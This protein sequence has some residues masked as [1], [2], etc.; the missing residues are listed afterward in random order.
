MR[1]N[2]PGKVQKFCTSALS[3]LIAFQLSGIPQLASYSVAYADENAPPTIEIVEDTPADLTGDPNPADGNQPGDD[4]PLEG[5]PIPAEGETPDPNPAEGDPAASDVKVAGDFVFNTKTNTIVDWVGTSTSVEIPATLE[6]EGVEYPVEHIGDQAFDLETGR[7]PLESITLNEGLKTIGSFAFSRNNIAFLSIP[8]S[9]VEIKDSA[10]E[11]N[12]LSD[13]FSLAI[14]PNSELVKIGNLAFSDNDLKGLDLTNAALLEEIGESAFAINELTEIKLPESIKKI[15]DRAFDQNDLSTVTLPNGLEEYGQEVFTNNGKY[16]VVSSTS[17]AVKD[18]VVEGKFG[19]V[20]HPVSIWITGIDTETGKTILTPRLYEFNSHIERKYDKLLLKGNVFSFTDV[21]IDNYSLKSDND[22]ELSNEFIEANSKENPK[23]LRYTPNLGDPIIENTEPMYIKFGTPADQVDLLKGVTAHDKAGDDLTDRLTAT[24]ATLDLNREGEYQIK[25]SVVDDNKRESIAYRTVFVGKDPLDVETGYGWLMRDFTYNGDT[26]T[27][28]SNTGR[29]KIKTHKKIVFPDFNPVSNPDGSNDTITM[30][31]ADDTF[32][33]K[34]LLEVVFPEKLTSFGDTKFNDNALTEVVIPKGIKAIPHSIFSDNKISSI[35]F[36]EGLESI[37]SI[38]FKNNELTYVDLPQNLKELDDRCFAYNKIAGHLDIP[39]SV[40][41]FGSGVFSNNLITSFTLPDTATEI[42]RGM[43]EENLI[44]DVKIPSTVTVIGQDAFKNNPVESIEFHDDVTEIG[45]NAFY[46]HHLHLDELILPSNIKVIKDEAFAPAYT[47]IEDQPHID[48]IV[49]PESIETIGDNAFRDNHIKEL[50]LPSHPVD[51][52]TG[53]FKNNDLTTVTIPDN[54]TEIADS[55]FS[56]NKLT[57]IHLPDSLV[58][59]GN[60]TFAGNELTEIQYPASLK[61]IGNKAFE[62]NDLTAV[63]IPEGIVKIGEGAFQDNAITSVSTPST[64][65]KISDKAFYGNPVSELTMSEGLEVIDDYAFGASVRGHNLESITFPASLKDIDTG[66]FSN[67]DSNS[68]VLKHIEFAPGSQLESIGSDAFSNNALTEVVL[69]P[70]VTS[71]QGSAFN[72]NPGW[73]PFPGRN[74]WTI[75]TTPETEMLKAPRVK[76]SIEKDGVPFTPDGLKDKV[77]NTYVA[78]PSILKIKHV[79]ANDPDTEIANATYR[80]AKRGENLQ[81]RPLASVYFQPVDNVATNVLMDEDVKEVVIQYN[82]TPEFDTTHFNI[83]MQHYDLRSGSR[84]EGLKDA[85]YRSNTFNFVVTVTSE[86]AESGASLHEP[87]VYIDLNQPVSGRIR[88]YNGVEL[89]DGNNITKNSTIEDGILRVQLNGDLNPGDTKDL[90]LTIRLNSAVPR[91]AIL[92]LTNAASLVVDEGE[93]TDGVKL[94]SNVNKLGLRYVKNPGT[95]D[96]ER[97]KNRASAPSESKDGMLFVAEGSPE[98]ND[99]VLETT[100]RL[101]DLPDDLHVKYP[102]PTYHGLDDQGTFK[103]DL[104]AEFVP[105]KNPAW[106]IDPT[107]EF[108]VA[109]FPQ[110][111]GYKAPKFNFPRARMNFPIIAE[112]LEFRVDDQ[113]VPGVIHGTFNE[114][115]DKFNAGNFDNIEYGATVQTATAAM[116]IFEPAKDT[117]PGGGQ[118]W[119]YQDPIEH[120][121]YINSA[122]V[123]SS[124]PGQVTVVDPDHLSSSSAPDFMSNGTRRRLSERLSNGHLHDAMYDIPAAREKEH[125]WAFSYMLSNSNDTYINKIVSLDDITVVSKDLDKRMKYTGVRLPNEFRKAKLEVFDNAEATGAPLMEKYIYQNRVDFSD[126]LADKIKSIKVTFSPADRINDVEYGFTKL[127]FYSKLKDPG[128]KLYTESAADILDPANLLNSTAVVDVPAR[129]HKGFLD[130]EVDQTF[131]HELTDSVAIVPVTEGEMEFT[132][133][134]V[135]PEYVEANMAV[136]Y[137]ITIKA[138]KP[139]D[140]AVENFKIMDVLPDCLVPTDVEFSSAFRRASTNPRFTFVKDIDGEGRWGV[141]VE[142]DEFDPTL[143]SSDSGY[144]AGSTTLYDAIVIKT[145]TQRYVKD[146]I[147]ANHVWMGF[148]SPM[149]DRN[150]PQVANKENRFPENIASIVADETSPAR[151]LFAAYPD[152]THEIETFDILASSQFAS[153]L[154]IK[155]GTS[156]NTPWGEETITLFGDK[157]YSYRINMMTNDQSLPN[158]MDIIQVLPYDDDVRLQINDDGVRSGRGSNLTGLTDAGDTYTAVP[159]MTGPVDADARYIDMFEYR[160]TT[161]S[162]AAIKATDE[163]NDLKNLNWVTADQLPQVNGKPD[164]SQVT[165]VRITGEKKGVHDACRISPN[166]TFDIPMMTPHNKGFALDARTGSASFVRW[167]TDDPTEEAV[168]SNTTSFNIISESVDINIRKLGV[169]T[170]LKREF[171]LNQV[172]FKL[173]QICEPNTPNSHEIRLNEFETVTVLNDAIKTFP[174]TYKGVITE[175]RPDVATTNAQGEAWYRQIATRFG[176]VLEETV[177]DG[178][179]PGENSILKI[180]PE[181]L[182]EALDDGIL[183]IEVKNTKIIKMTPLQP[184]TMNLTFNKVGMENNPLGYAQFEL[185]ATSSTGYKYSQRAT[186]KVIDG[187]VLF[188]NIPAFGELPDANGNGE[189]FVLSE[190]KAPGSLIPIKPI[191]ITFAKNIDPATG[192]WLPKSEVVRDADGDVIEFTSFGYEDL[193]GNTFNLGDI[194]NRKVDIQAYVIGLKGPDEIAKSVDKLRVTDGKRLA[195]MDVDV[196]EDP[197]MTQNV[198]HLTSDENGRIVLR[199][200]HAGKDYYFKQTS[201]EDRDREY[202]KHPKV[203]VVKVRIDKDGSLYVNDQLQKI[204]YAVL[205]NIPREFKNILEIYKT[206]KVLGQG[207][208]VEGAIFTLF[209][210]DE[211]GNKLDPDTQDTPFDVTSL[212][213]GNITCDPALTKWRGKTDAAGRLRFVDFATEPGEDGNKKF[214]KKNF[215]LEETKP[216]IGYSG[217]FAPQKFETI[218]DK[219]YYNSFNAANFPIVLSLKKTIYGTDTPV[220]GAEFTLYDTI[221][222]TGNVLAKATTDANGIAKF[223]YEGFETS[224]DYSVKETRV[225]DGFNAETLTGVIG[226]HLIDWENRIGWDGTVRVNATNLLANPQL[227]IRKFDQYTKRALEGVEFELWKLN[228]DGDVRIADQALATNQNGYIYY[229]NLEFGRYRL[230]ETKPLDYFKELNPLEFTIGKTGNYVKTLYNE[231][232]PQGYTLKNIAELTDGQDN[233]TYDLKDVTYTLKLMEKGVPVTTL[234]TVTTDDQGELKLP[235][236][237]FGREYLLE[238]DTQNASPREE[239]GVISEY[240]HGSWKLDLVDNGPGKKGDLRVRPYDLT[241]QDVE[242]TVDNE[243]DAINVVN[244]VPM[245]VVDL[246]INKRF[247]SGELLEDTRYAVEVFSRKQNETDEQKVK[248]DVVELMPTADA[249]KR[250]ATLKGVAGFYL[251]VDEGKFEQNVFSYNEIIESKN[252]EAKDA[253]VL[254]YRSEFTNTISETQ[255]EPSGD[256]GLLNG[257]V[258]VVNTMTPALAQLDM[259]LDWDGPV[260]PETKPDTWFKLTRKTANGTVEDVDMVKVVDGEATVVDGKITVDFGQQPV[261]DSHGSPYTYTLVQTDE[262][263][264]PAVPAHFKQTENDVVWTPGIYDDNEAHTFDVLNTHIVP[265]A[266]LTVDLTWSGNDI[267]ATKPTTYFILERKVEDG[268]YELVEL[269]E[270]PDGTTSHSWLQVDVVND[271]GK[272]YTYRVTQVDENGEK[273]HPEGFE[274]E[275]NNITWTGEMYAEGQKHTFEFINKRNKEVK[276]PVVPPVIEPP[277]VVPPVIVPPVVVPPVVEPPVVVPVVPPV[278]VP[279]EPKPVVV[280]PPAEPEPKVV[281]PRTYDNSLDGKALGVLAG[282]GISGIILGFILNRKKK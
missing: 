199:N 281:V 203:D 171:P 268:E 63:H 208:P 112:H 126:Q 124:S 273:G 123:G 135:K 97:Q 200:V 201:A 206:D 113:P 57:E 25:I 172:Q 44:K 15:E 231:R 161:D 59:I 274:T 250:S 3:M 275:E 80:F 122:Q 230:V 243:N 180:T 148:E 23:V 179:K 249:T 196:A 257:S 17:I 61:S 214:H 246:T 157:P 234:G 185:T 110:G 102:I 108:L 118:E 90:K 210:V 236:L 99:V 45:Y 227:I 263:G 104:K 202:K 27:G 51:M 35:E 271:E 6:I 28:L 158:A 49:I 98:A 72:K 160:Y 20:S 26:V 1:R 276:P 71:I 134:Q 78:N 197:A 159:K 245:P 238:Q 2:E 73:Q 75:D 64:L 226:I 260:L 83:K 241:M 184:M 86:E 267:P 22:Q 12:K 174:Q 81:A 82:P 87:W 43:F 270:F 142:A 193:V 166:L 251:N 14:R 165:A 69:P 228:D 4:A 18:S 181:M 235:D 125:T 244:K 62:Q 223:D 272:P 55:V 204:S 8:A 170:L 56:Y 192:E 141:V 68:D 32:A 164:F 168:E 258:D 89:R 84:T 149:S 50:T 91:D 264:T 151:M 67:K 211:D 261:V 96:Y 9:V 156:P 107:G 48:K 280:V 115:S 173:W 247:E 190:I 187:K 34:D 39:E 191:K 269:V 167:I 111:T 60:S 282:L 259:K 155:E 30:I 277:V 188:E 121:H 220:E 153:F 248:L 278:V 36:P 88:E 183:E 189:P 105:E 29:E 152:A 215:V 132:M 212:Q 217:Q 207:D 93:G 136:D 177:P 252:Q 130:Q 225:P 222:G 198:Q 139:Y 137:P 54:T 109:T 66:A 205:P 33:E 147:Y 186:S 100:V 169:D 256:S 42:P 182:K 79:L 117:N 175:H 47:G 40:T 240:T 77:W 146:G 94:R 95:I 176:Y 216:P 145:K 13:K 103:Y 209:E 76:V 229:P 120:V 253:N 19:S 46:H 218:E 221:D 74:I 101:V 131:H 140:V 162:T 7:Q 224:K 10:F 92:D 239:R 154:T 52:Q 219:I 242:L 53:A 138:F 85:D 178:Y 70:T 119:N 11:A 232:M 144:P 194:V 279:V 133:E 213:T 116:H 237:V 127:L 266:D 195:Y 129:I 254:A 31:L 16:V 233:V 114:A 65:K 163:P 262:N 106:T 128:K 37:Q 41:D 24:P 5:E 255:F 265:K 150:I 21:D 38:A 58:E 143:D